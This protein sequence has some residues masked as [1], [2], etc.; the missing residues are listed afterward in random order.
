MVAKLGCVYV[1]V[2]HAFFHHNYAGRASDQNYEAINIRPGYKSL[3][4]NIALAY[5]RYRHDDNTFARDARQQDFLRQAKDQLGVTGLLTHYQDILGALGKSISTNIRSSTQV[6][7]LVNLVL[8]DARRPGP[9]GPVPGQPDQVQIGR[10]RLPDAAS[11][12][13]IRADRRASSRTPRRRPSSAARARAR[14]PARA[15]AVGRL[16]R[17]RTPAPVTTTR[18]ARTGRD[19]RAHR[20]AVVDARRGA[21]SWRRTLPFKVELPTLT[22]DWAAQ[23]RGT[24]RLL[25]LPAARPRRQR[26]LGLPH[27][28]GRTPRPRGA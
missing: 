26:A 2:D 8:F 13:E 27:H 15:S 12:A 19:R 11:K 10:R 28:L 6:A 23:V 1:D 14:R 21:R 7:R 24:V 3:C 22:S 18:T 9:P 16:E 4:G 20:D 17:R 25:R 5:V